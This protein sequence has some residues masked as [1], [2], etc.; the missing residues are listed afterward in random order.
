[1]WL[2]KKRGISLIEIMGGDVFF[3]FSG[4]GG[5]GGGGAISNMAPP[6]GG[7]WVVV[8]DREGGNSFDKF[9]VRRKMVYKKWKRKLISTISTF[10]LQ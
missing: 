9:W 3:F 7:V 6:L 10:I 1:M 8:V 2:Q 4:G 5:G